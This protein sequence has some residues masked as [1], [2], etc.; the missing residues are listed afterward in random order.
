[1][2]TI[3]YALRDTTLLLDEDERRYTLTIRDLPEEDK[4][5]EK[6]LKNGPSALTARELLAIILV[7][8]TTKEDVLS[9][10]S[11]IMKE[12]GEKLIMDRTDPAELAAE[13]DIP[14][15]KALQMVAVSEL[16]R[17]FYA[18]NDHAAP[19]LR[20]ARDVYEHVSAMRT[21]PKEHLRGLYLNAHYKLIHD[22]VISI[23][24]LDSN[25]LHPRDVFRPALEYS[26]AGIILAHNHPSGSIEAS[27]PDI[28][29]TEQL[30][31]AGT[32]IGIDL[33]D[34]VIVSKEGFRSVPVAYR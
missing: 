11:R 16:G 3:P 25:I 8:G 31:E 18:K 2:H 20:T 15:G 30:V 14:I 28:R 22:E 12:Y 10:S 6:L 1:M 29:I 19:T 9:M 7:S 5:R 27:A 17:R 13:L 24:T 32:L 21:L 26:A 4:P 33:I 34:H 23:G